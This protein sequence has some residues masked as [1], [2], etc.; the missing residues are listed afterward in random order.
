MKDEDAKVGVRVILGKHTAVL[1][2]DAPG[3]FIFS[4]NPKMDNYIG[5]EAT[6]TKVVGRQPCGRLVVHV[7]I[8]AEQ[9]NW[10]VYDMTLFE[11]ETEEEKKQKIN[12]LFDI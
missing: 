4:W 8:D 3:S 10:R 6:I 5:K 1:G 12:F 7:D 2:E 11:A 9:W